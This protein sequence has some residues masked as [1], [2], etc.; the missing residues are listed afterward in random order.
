MQRELEE[1]FGQKL[2]KIMTRVTQIKYKIRIRYKRRIL[3]AKNIAI[4]SLQIRANSDARC[5]HRRRRRILRLLLLL[6]GQPAELLQPRPNEIVGEIVR[7]GLSTDHRIDARCGREGC[8]R[9]GCG[10]NAMA[11]RIKRGG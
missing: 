6:V 4:E 10:S 7:H 3:V 9:H 2:N 11:E 1:R 8:R 5:C